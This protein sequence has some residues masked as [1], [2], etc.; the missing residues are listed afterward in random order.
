MIDDTQIE[1]NYCV[2]ALVDPRDGMFR[3][4]GK[5]T[6]ERVRTRAYE[7]LVQG[8]GEEQNAKK[9]N[10]LRKL[11]RL[12]LEASLKPLEWFTTEED[13]YAAEEQW[14]TTV[15]EQIGNK[16]TNICEGGRGGCTTSKE[17]RAKYQQFLENIKREAEDY[18]QTQKAATS[19]TKTKVRLINV[20]PGERA[21]IQKERMENS[22]L[23]ERLS[24]HF[25]GAR[26]GF[27]PRTRPCTSSEGLTFDSVKEAA[28]HYRIHSNTVTWSL[29]HRH[30]IDCNGKELLFVYVN[31]E[32]YAKGPKERPVRCSDGREFPSVTKAALGAGTTYKTVRRCLEQDR[33]FNGLTFEYI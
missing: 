18:R 29:T 25:K 14:I 1:I 27:I 19:F 4:I 12:G 10:W 30:P 23:R 13:A 32:D 9:A 26:K 11:D 8:K 17:Q 2:Y 16:L 33:S 22:Q 3:Y 20:T 7:H 5:T 31:Q 6:K 21:E 28:E 15:R 24:Q